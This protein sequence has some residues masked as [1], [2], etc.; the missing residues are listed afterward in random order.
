MSCWKEGG[1]AGTIMNTYNAKFELCEK[2]QAAVGS[3]LGA[4]CKTY[5]LKDDEHVRGLFCSNVGAIATTVEGE[6]A[7][8]GSMAK[9]PEKAFLFG[10][11]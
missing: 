3:C 6:S 9:C 10:C 5:G 4:Q 1:V 7:Y 8:Y 11:R 2:Y